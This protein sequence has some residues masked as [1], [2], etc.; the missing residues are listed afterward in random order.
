MHLFGGVDE[1]EEQ[2]ERAGGHSTQRERQRVHHM[3]QRLERGRTIVRSPA[4]AR[5]ATQ[6]IHGGEGFFALEPTDNAAECCGETPNVFVER[7]VYIA[8]SENGVTA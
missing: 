5:Q 4:R 3:E 6:R 1:Q 2:R 7:K 8:C